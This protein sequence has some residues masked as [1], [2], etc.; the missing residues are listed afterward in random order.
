MD[1]EKEKSGWSVVPKLIKNIVYIGGLI[2]AIILVLSIKGCIDNGNRADYMFD[3]WNMKDNEQMKVIKNKLGQLSYIQQVTELN[4]K[5]MKAYV[6]NDEKL[7]ALTDKY[8][9]LL[10]VVSK[11]MGVYVDSVLVF[12]AGK[13]DTLPCA[14]FEKKDT[15]KT[16]YY[17]FNYLM[18]KRQFLLTNLSFPDTVHTI[19]GERKK[20]FL[21]LRREFVIEETHSNKYVKIQQLTPVVAVKK[22]RWPAWLGV[23][24]AT[25]LVGGYMLFK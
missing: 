24:V 10:A 18:N 11:K 15:I 13:T 16:R 20:G 3:K 9:S 2:V 1:W 12:K 22:N 19:I 14:D 5:Q 6:E 4:Q 25:G 21:N 23:G 8:S 17:S 7:K